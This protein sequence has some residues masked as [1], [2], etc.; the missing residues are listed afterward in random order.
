MDKRKILIPMDGSDVSRKILLPVCEFF[1]PDSYEIL[2]LRA[3][4]VPSSQ[5]DLSNVTSRPM[6]LGPYGVVT[7]LDQEADPHPIFRDTEWSSFEEKLRRELE[8]DITDLRSKGYDVSVAIHFGK[9]AEEI[10]E[11]AKLQHVALVAMA[12]HGR[13]GVKRLLEGSVTEDVLH[14]LSIPMMII[15]VAEA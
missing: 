8:D 7:T 5:F 10:V 3:A 12:S 11:L 6:I 4:P 15:N 1:S 2:L 9:P 13:A 14:H